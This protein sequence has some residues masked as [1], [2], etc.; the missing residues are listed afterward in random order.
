MLCLPKPGSMH[1]WEEDAPA[2]G[3][4]KIWTWNLVAVIKSACQDVSACKSHWIPHT[5]LW[6]PA[7]PAEEPAPPP[8]RLYTNLYNSDAMICKHEELQKQPPNPG[9]PPGMECVVVTI[10]MYSD[11]T[12]LAN[13]GTA[14]LWPI[15]AYFLNLSKYVHLKPSAFVVHHLAYVPSVSIRQSVMLAISY[16]VWRS[17]PPTSSNTMRRSIVNRHP[18][19]LFDSSSTVSCSRYGSCCLMTSSW[20]C[21]SMAC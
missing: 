15:Y 6:H 21:T 19:L 1:N 2:A 20:R 9:D 12:H 17:S 18:R 13:F 14:S 8:E 11:S 4:N 7:T 3:V 5:L 16:L 10:S